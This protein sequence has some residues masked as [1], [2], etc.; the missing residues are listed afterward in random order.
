LI[1]G[2]KNAYFSIESKNT[3]SHNVGAWDRV[4]TSYN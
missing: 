3:A 4:M 2:F 1:K